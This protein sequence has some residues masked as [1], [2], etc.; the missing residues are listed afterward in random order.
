MKKR[1]DAKLTEF[2]HGL[3]S[4]LSGNT[5]CVGA[6][7]DR[8]KFGKGI[9]HKA[10]WYQYPLTYAEHQYM[11]SHGEEAV[12]MRYFQFGEWNEHPYLPVNNAKDF[13]ECMA[14]WTR[15]RFIKAGGIIPKGE[16]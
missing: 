4:V 7:C 5:P 11:H 14:F 6:H 13:F 10:H 16:K 2:C 9:G 1:P 3:R 12:F 8:V 15:Q